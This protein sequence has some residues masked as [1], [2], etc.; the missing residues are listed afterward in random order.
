[1]VTRYNGSKR[2]C[3]IIGAVPVEDSSLFE[4]YAVDDFFVI[5]ADAGYLTA[6]KYGIV[7]DIILGDFDSAPKPVN[8]DVRV[9]T[10]PVEKDVTDAMYAAQTGIKLGFL[11]FVLVG[12]LGGER[13]DHTIANF[14]VIHYLHT[15]SAKAELVSETESVTLLKS[16]TLK[17][18]DSVGDTL[19][20]FPYNGSS[21]TVTYKGLQYPLS[22]HKLTIGVGIMGVSNTVTENIAE[23]TVHQ[24]EALLILKKVS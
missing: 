2:K 3:M 6:E 18:T 1:M 8:K 5:C 23:I 16:G 20:V 22:Y 19:S 10:L 17:I 12:C 7:P 13:L 15:Y 11:S 4:R 21:C 24:G 9:I 14:E